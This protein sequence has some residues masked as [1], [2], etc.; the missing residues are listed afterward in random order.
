MSRPLDITQADPRDGLYKTEAEIAALVGVGLDKWRAN[1]AV[2]EKRGL[3]RR[4]PLFCDR[5]YWPAVRACLDRLEG[6]GTPSVPVLT[7]PDGEEN[8]NAAGK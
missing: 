7:T 5:R 3:P 4:N 6:L 2:L 8:W 1:A